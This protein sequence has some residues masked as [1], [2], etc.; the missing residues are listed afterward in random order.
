[1]S[2]IMIKKEIRRYIRTSG[3][4]VSFKMICPI[5]KLFN[6]KYKD[7]DSKQVAFLANIIIREVH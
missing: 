2:E 6:M 1:M 5:V 3:L 4:N 7:V